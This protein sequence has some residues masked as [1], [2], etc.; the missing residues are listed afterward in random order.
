VS[1]A[2]ISSVLVVSALV[3]ACTGGGGGLDGELTTWT[4][5]P[6]YTEQAGTTREA[7]PGYVERSAGSREAEQE[8]VETAPGTSAGGG[9]GTGGLDCSG[10][11][12]CAEAGKSRTEEI[13]LRPNSVGCAVV[14]EDTLLVFAPDGTIQVGSQQ[15]GTWASTGSGFSVTIKDDTTTCTKL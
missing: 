15:V 13:T 11:Y 3:T 7:A 6:Q 9:A 8:S 10:T 5:G 14:V 12:A 1:R 2:S 4:P